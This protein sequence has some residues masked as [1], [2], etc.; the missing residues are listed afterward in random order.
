MQVQVVTDTTAGASVGCARARETFRV[1]K[2]A[3]LSCNV[4]V[5]VGGTFVN[6]SVFLQVGSTVAKEARQ[7][8]LSFVNW[9]S[10]ARVVTVRVNR[11]QVRH[12]VN[13]VVVLRRSV[14]V[15]RSHLE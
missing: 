5:P 10:L 6:T 3:A 4:K 14:E 8:G 11:Q 13:E 7:T 2:F 9:A 12:L 1:T 15:E